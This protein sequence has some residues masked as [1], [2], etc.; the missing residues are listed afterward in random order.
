M[1]PSNQLCGGR[2]GSEV[3]NKGGTELLAWRGGGGQ[4]DRDRQTEGLCFLLIADRDRPRPQIPPVECKGER[5]QTEIHSARYR[6]SIL[7]RFRRAV[8]SQIFI[9]TVS[10][11]RL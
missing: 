8:V 5:V 1:I 6:A 4:T 11:S 7:H 2:G 9:S 10:G 3:R